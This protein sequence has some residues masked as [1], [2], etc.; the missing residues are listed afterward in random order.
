M[1]AKDGFHAT[2]AMRF[3]REMTSA[4]KKP[5]D[6]MLI[7]VEMAYTKNQAAYWLTDLYETTS[8]SFKDIPLDK[9]IERGINDWCAENADGHQFFGR[10][11]EEAANNCMKYQL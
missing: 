5:H 3:A 6:R 11:A 8:Q 9:Q 4:M 10:T 1:N 2:A 7:E